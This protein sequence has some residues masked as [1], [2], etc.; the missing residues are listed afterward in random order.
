MKTMKLYMT[1]KCGNIKFFYMATITPLTSQIYVKK[2][3]ISVSSFQI[4]VQRGFMNFAIRL[5]S[6]LAEQYQYKLNVRTKSQEVDPGPKISD[7]TGDVLEKFR[8]LES[9]R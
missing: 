2:K 1:N 8:S 9:V 3:R 6:V 4:K 5:S 7:Y